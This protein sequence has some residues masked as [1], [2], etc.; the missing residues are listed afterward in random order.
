MFGHPYAILRTPTRY[1]FI[2]IFEP[3][4]NNKR[5]EPKV[6]VSIVLG[7]IDN[8]YTFIEQYPKE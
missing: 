2:A 5:S 1:P 6:R 3:C 7:K 8:T 4:L